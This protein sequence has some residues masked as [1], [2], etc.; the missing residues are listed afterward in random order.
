MIIAV[1]TAG[2]AESIVDVL[3]VA[4]VRSISGTSFEKQ[5]CANY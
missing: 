1:A 5:F 3:Y 2:Y 4:Y